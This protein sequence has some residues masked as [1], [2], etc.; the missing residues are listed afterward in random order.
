[1]T[2]SGFAAYDPE[3]WTSELSGDLVIREAVEGDLGGL[4]GIELTGITR[5]RDSWAELIRC[6]QEDENRHL[7]IAEVDG[8]LVAFA[9]AHF[10]AEHP[11]DRAPAGYYLAGVTVVPGFRRAGLGRALTVARIGWISGRSDEVWFFASVANAASIDL[12]REFGF[13][14]VL[15]APAIHGVTFDAG[16]GILCRLDLQS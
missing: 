1:M 8:A 3:A 14:E 16:E 2:A 9:Q 5:T 13:Q 11:I 15:R 10:L 12:H 4:A 6:S 7:L